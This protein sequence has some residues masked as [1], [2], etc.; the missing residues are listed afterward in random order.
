M[1][2]VMSSPDK[3]GKY[4]ITDVIGEG[5]GGVVF[6]AF[7]PSLQRV[8]AVKRLRRALPSEAD[9]AHAVAARLR[10]Q[11]QA[12]SRVAHQGI[13][14]VYEI[15]EFR[16]HAFIAMEHVDGLNLEQW[17]AAAPL[18]PQAALLQVME[19]LL[20][21][22][23]CAH[24]SGVRHGDIK[25]TNLIVTTTGLVKITDFGLARAEGRTGG[26]AGVAPEY[27]SGRLI[28]HRVDLYAA[29]AIL[30]RMLVG[31]DPFA[32]ASDR[33]AVGAALRP[34]GMIAA[35][36]RP[37]TFDA[38]VAKA[39]AHDPNQRFS[40]A[41]EF[42]EALHGT[43][44][45]RLCEQSAGIMVRVVSDGGPIG[46]EAG[47]PAPAAGDV[48]GRPTRFAQRGGGAAASIPTL[49][50]AIPPNVLA[51]PS[52]DPWAHHRVEGGMAP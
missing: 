45:R 24:L 21:A 29:G 6:R 32:D 23:E 50:I 3:V 43:V 33:P 35:A 1:T 22:L 12:V 42:R 11:A 2:I 46:R 48:G 31:R 52:S 13:V 47:D 26:A 34:P 8:V 49:T 38:I 27:L 25:P 30:Y 41:A 40:S 10:E 28:D 7:D 51:M 44:E 37:S 4:R 16:G 17:L 20:D 5:A 15:D 36:H 19:Q 18:P 39:L 9:A 14:A